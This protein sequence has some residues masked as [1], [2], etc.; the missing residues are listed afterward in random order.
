MKYKKDCTCDKRLTERLSYNIITHVMKTNNEFI[1]KIAPYERLV[2]YYETDRMGIVHHSNYIRWFEECRLY[3]MQQI[4]I[5]YKD[6]E[7]R[8]IMIPVLSVDCTYRLP[9][10]YGDTFVIY[11]S[12]TKFNGIK[13]DISYEVYKK[14][15]DELHCTGSSSHCFVTKDMKP[16]SVKKDY[17]DVYEILKNAESR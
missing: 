6:I 14:G 13:M 15:S 12:L 11:E 4:G 9:F 7:D 1:D 2:Q 5:D 17:P 10:K 16:T 8:G 3:Y